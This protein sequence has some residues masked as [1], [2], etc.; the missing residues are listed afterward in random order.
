MIIKKLKGH[1]GCEIFLCEENG[2]K[3]VR[4]ISP[5]VD[6]NNRLILQMKKQSEFTNKAIKTPSVLAEGINE[7]GNYYFDM[8]YIGGVSLS[9]FIG[10]SDINT[11]KSIINNLYNFCHSN[12]ELENIIDVTSIIK[13]KISSISLIHQDVFFEKY[14][15]YCIE[16][17]WKNTIMG[18]CHGDM[19]FE[20]IIVYKS[21]L[22]L[23]DFLDS[24]IESPY[25]DI[26]KMLQDLLVMWSWR[27]ESVEPF[28]KNIILYDQIIKNL[29]TEEK[30]TIVRLLIINLLRIIPYA[31]KKNYTFVKNAISFLGNKLNIR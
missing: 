3:F 16:Y 30:D 14:K 18:K 27:E 1:S 15:R 9:R 7:K 4:K 29:S 19:T 31:D 8:D 13:N 2:N 10:T 17:D 26:S 28:V 20:N 21:E 23:I 25:I 5:S 11:S 24:F 6:Y 22:Y 12:L